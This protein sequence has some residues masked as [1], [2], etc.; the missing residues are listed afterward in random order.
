M[1]SAAWRQVILT[2]PYLEPEMKSVFGTYAQSR[3][4]TA[5]LT[6]KTT[7]PN[8]ALNQI[9]LPMRQV[10][11]RIAVSSVLEQV[12]AR[13]EYFAKNVL[14]KI[15]RNQ[16]PFTL[17][18]VPSYLE[19]VSLRNFLLKREADYFV[20]VTEYSRHTEVS[21]GRARFGQG[22]KSIMLYTGRAH[23]FHRHAI[24]GVRH[25][26]WYGL[27]SDPSVYHQVIDWCHDEETQTR[28]S[29]AVPESSVLTLYTSYEALA[30]ERIVGHSHC[31]RMTKGNKKTFFF[32]T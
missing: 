4:G 16:Q 25:V 5:R 21:R 20:S 12:D 14:R 10:F 30:L 13:L 8:A 31:S 2:A 23:F 32:A 26:I 18:F 17:I 1:S 15:D 24:R 3:A 19:F 11:Q 22:R 9:A 7:W 27:P 6:R 28:H 29:K